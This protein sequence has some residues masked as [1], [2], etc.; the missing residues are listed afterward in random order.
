M[1]GYWQRP[2]ATSAAL[3]NGWLHNRRTSCEVD[4][5]GRV[6]IVDR[7]KDIIIRGGENIFQYRG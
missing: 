2:D 1:H 6:H 5:A 4:E 7:T 3:T